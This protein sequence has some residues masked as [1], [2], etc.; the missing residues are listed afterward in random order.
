MIIG[1]WLC[2]K[3]LLGG[4]HLAWTALCA[5]VAATIIDNYIQV[6]HQCNA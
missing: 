2:E 4:F 3:G 6:Y 5:P 1:D